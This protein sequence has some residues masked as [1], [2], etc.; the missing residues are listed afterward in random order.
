MLTLLPKGAQTKL[1]KFFYLKIFFH[2]PPVSLTPVVHLEPRISPRI[3]ENIWNSRNS[4]LRCLG[5]TNSWK[6][7]KSK[8]SW[9]CPFKPIRLRS[10]LFAQNCG[11]PS[12]L[13]EERQWDYQAPPLFNLL[14]CH[15]NIKSINIDDLMDQ[16]EEIF[17]GFTSRMPY[18]FW[19]W[20]ISTV[21]DQYQ[22]L[23]SQTALYLGL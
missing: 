17:W 13:S 6:N 5:E 9:H 11:L 12:L 10:H 4:I 16:Y 18:V 14:N 2:L 3:F 15:V 20:R 22:G 8:I 19:F 1:L 21:V 7:Q 23:I